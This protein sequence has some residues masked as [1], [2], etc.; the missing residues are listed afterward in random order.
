MVQISLTLEQDNESWEVGSP[1]HVYQ[2]ERL[3]K[4]VSFFQYV[5][6]EAKP[7][8]PTTGGRSPVYLAVERP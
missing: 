5:L 8:N 7:A 2:P 1:R 4:A 3:A 6:N